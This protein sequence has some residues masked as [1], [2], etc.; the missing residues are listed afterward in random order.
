MR[1]PDNPN[2]TLNIY[3]TQDPSET[4]D[5]VVGSLALDSIG[6]PGIPNEHSPD[7]RPVGVLTAFCK[8]MQV[9]PMWVNGPGPGNRGEATFGVTAARSVQ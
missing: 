9:C 1:G 2:Y 7:G 6:L 5:F 8:G 3:N 4:L